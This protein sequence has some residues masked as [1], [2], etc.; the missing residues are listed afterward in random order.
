ME[1]VVHNISTKIVEEIIASERGART[2]STLMMLSFAFGLL[3]I[4]L[5]PFLLLMT[6][7]QQS[8]ILID[9]KG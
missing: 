5:V 4:A 7:T 9:E 1:A 8:L 6:S 3:S 2:Y